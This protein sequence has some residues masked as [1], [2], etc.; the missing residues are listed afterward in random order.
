MEDY[1]DHQTDLNSKRG[2]H[3]KAG[4][5][6]FPAGQVKSALPPPHLLL[7]VHGHFSDPHNAAGFSSLIVLITTLAITRSSVCE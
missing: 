6:Q 7:V 5:E 4:T 1:R 2:G 3:P